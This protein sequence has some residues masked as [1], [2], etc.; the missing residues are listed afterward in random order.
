[1]SR[2]AVWSLH[3]SGRN[4]GPQDQAKPSKARPSQGHLF[5]PNGSNGIDPFP[6]QHENHHARLFPSG[7]TAWPGGMPDDLCIEQ[8]DCQCGTGSP[9]LL[10]FPCF[11]A[12]LS[13][14]FACLLPTRR[15]RDG[16]YIAP[17]IRCRPGPRGPPLVTAGYP[18]ART[19]K[20]RVIACSEAVRFSWAV[21]SAADLDRRAA[22]EDRPREPPLPGHP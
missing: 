4:S 17:T 20:V 13:V 22:Q 21:C 18:S 2:D 3:H 19:G 10:R 1:M 5:R 14:F 11:D 7:L 9:F 15:R 8:K 6:D 12:S 16:V